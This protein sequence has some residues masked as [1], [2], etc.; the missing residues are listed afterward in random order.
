MNR[1][2][3][4]YWNLALAIGHT[5][6]VDYKQQIRLFTLNAFATISIILVIGFVST[7]VLLGSPSAL[8]GLF[9]L[10]V[11]VGVLYLNQK[12]YFK[13]AR[14]LVVFLLSFIVL[15]M[16]IADRRT[17]TEYVLIAVACSS[18]LFF[19]D[20]VSIFLG[21][22]LAL[23]C[24]GFYSWYDAVYPFV[25]D[26]TVPYQYMEKVVQM[27]SVFAVVVQL[28]VFRSLINRYAKKVEDVNNEIQSANEELKASN[29]EHHALSEQLD[30]IV[31]QKSTELQSYL[32]AINIHIYSAVTDTN[33]TILKVN[34][35]LTAVTGFTEEELVGKNFNVFNSGHHPD[36]FFRHLFASLAEGKTWRGEVKNRRKDG[37]FFWIDM[38]VIPLKNE[39]GSVNYYL[40]LALP[41]TERKQAEE[42]KEKTAKMLESIAFSASHKVRGP[43]ARIQGLMNLIDNGN[44][45]LT[46]VE[47]ISKYLRLSV[48]EMDVATRELTSFINTQHDVDTFA[49]TFGN[50]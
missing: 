43:I 32:D 23:V 16:A 34:E 37:S 15:A 45:D 39:K 25:A 12:H 3:I 33:G 38:V 1:F 8:Q 13:L 9:I 6:D 29:E 30:W 26:P 40:T 42:Q 49:P 48:N 24:F 41:I 14:F 18:I 44:I 2:F 36:H 17:G 5:T 20:L 7:F 31:R 35:P 11:M 19:E 50:G 4:E 22:L 47:S 28:L 46:E 21:F 27:I 10:P